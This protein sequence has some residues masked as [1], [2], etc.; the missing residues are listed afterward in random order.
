VA[1]AP[2]FFLFGGPVGDHTASPMANKS[3]FFADFAECGG[4]L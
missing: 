2:P 1:E 3:I 4:S